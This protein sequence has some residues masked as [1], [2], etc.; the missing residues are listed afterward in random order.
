MLRDKPIRRE[1][2]RASPEE[3]VGKK[4]AH[5]SPAG[6]T[7]TALWRS[8]LALLRKDQGSGHAGRFQESHP[9][10]RVRAASP[11]PRHRPGPASQR[12]PNAQN[13]S[14][15]WGAHLST[16]G[17]APLTAAV[18]GLSVH[19]T[20]GIRWEGEAELLL[21][22]SHTAGTCTHAQ[23]HPHGHACVCTGIYTRV[24]V[25][26]GR[27]RFPYKPLTLPAG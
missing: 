23:I 18:E 21:E 15:G 17:R 27:C 7:R 26:K 19:R 11:R 4:A 6:G 13:P 22:L 2:P 16:P 10:G 3:A 14:R 20:P 1:A 25:H 5:P 24:C 8:V 12:T 9:T